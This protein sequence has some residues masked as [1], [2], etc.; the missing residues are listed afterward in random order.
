MPKHL[1]RPSGWIAASVLTAVALL[2]AS[3]SPAPA[4]TAGLPPGSI[5]PTDRQRAIARRVGTILEEAHFRRAKIDDKLSAQVYDR[6][7]DLLDGQRSYFLQSDLADFASSRLK[8]DDMINTGD[9]EP[10]YLI[11][12]RFQ[13]RNRERVNY[14]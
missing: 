8:F 1:R 2:L 14:A 10:A 5:T 7:L 12:A 13:Q 9:L 11:F 4:N 3:S 6:Y